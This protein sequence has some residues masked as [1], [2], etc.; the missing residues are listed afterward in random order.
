MAKTVL[1]LLLSYGSDR[2]KSHSQSWTTIL[3]I[4]A[5]SGMEIRHQT[6]L[7]YFH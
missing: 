1:H 4:V 5:M 3:G 2:T 6:Q 7:H